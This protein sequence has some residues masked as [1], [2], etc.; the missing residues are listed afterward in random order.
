MAKRS[1][2]RDI[3]GVFSS[4]T[5]SLIASLLI[6]VV[7]TRVL[8]PEDFGVY[9]SIL[10][11]PLVTVGFVQMG[12]RRSAVFHIGKKVF[13]EQRIVSSVFVLLI[14]ASVLGMLFSLA[15]F[16]VYDH[17]DFLSNYILVVLLTIPFK[18]ALLYTGGIFLGKEDI[19]SS[20]VQNWIPLVLNLIFVCLFVWIAKMGVLGA[21]LAYLISSCIVSI[22]YVFSLGRKYNV[23]LRIDKE[24]MM[25]LFRTGILFAISFVVIQLNLRI[26]LLILARIG[27]ATD[28]GL[29]SLAVQI[30][31]QLWLLPSA[32]GV[33]VMSRTAN[34]SSHENSTKETARLM[35]ITLLGGIL[36]AAILAFLVPIFVPLIFG[37]RFSGS[38]VLINY[39]LPG[40]IMFMIFR[41]LNGQ[42]SGMGK[43]GVAAIAFFIAL[44]INIV[45][46][47]LWIPEFGAKGAA[48]A[49]NISYTIGTI[50][51]T[52]AYCKIS[53]VSARELFALKK[54]DFDF[55][56][57]RIQLWSAKFDK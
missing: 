36:L 17:P 53:K 24:V 40:V 21:L 8:G 57:K 23:V 33:V 38:G 3:S 9:Y 39:L 46:N 47:V 18:L 32:V 44:V 52:I 12:I 27:D 1:Y 51:L 41:V 50:G 49:T 45:L 56:R 37:N 5:I 55:L 43:P 7:L 14:I 26:D 54:S 11:I 31:E 28:T 13:S 2:F 25:R 19:K 10:V 4:Y 42:L 15:G 30:V 29:Y 16:I 6:Y 35:R 48:W 34:T 22:Y 20:N